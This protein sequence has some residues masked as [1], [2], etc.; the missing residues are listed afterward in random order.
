MFLKSQQVMLAI[1][2]NIVVITYC[3]GK[4]HFAGMDKL[5]EHD[6]FKY[7]RPRIRGWFNN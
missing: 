6:S 3:V 1:V 7:Y 2:K 5:E 4:Y